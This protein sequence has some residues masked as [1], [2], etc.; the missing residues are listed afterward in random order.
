MPVY[1]A[2]REID[3]DATPAECFAVLTDYERMPAWQSRVA[4]CNVL[5]L[6]ADGRADEVEY[7][8]D[9]NLR[10]VRYRL[11]HSYDEPSWIGSEYAGGDFRHFAGDYRLGESADGTRVTFRLEI[12]PGMTIPAPLAKL[13][14]ETV[15]GRALQ[16]LKSRVERVTA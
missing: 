12:D 9:A 13:L 8:I 1:S 15:V 11:R 16:D 5:S 6:G 4:E 14:G 7:A 10:T 2:T 3:I